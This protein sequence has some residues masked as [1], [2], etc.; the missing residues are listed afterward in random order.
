[1]DPFPAL[2]EAFL[3][4]AEANSGLRKESFLEQARHHIAEGKLRAS[5]R[6]FSVKWTR[7]LKLD[8]G[9]GLIFRA[10]VPRENK[11]ES[12]DR[13]EIPPLAMADHRLIFV[14]G[15]KVDCQ[16][17]RGGSFDYW[18]A[19]GAAAYSVCMSGWKDVRGVAGDVERL[20]PRTATSPSAIAATDAG[21]IEPRKRGPK[22]ETMKRVKTEMRAHAADDLSAMKIVEMESTFNASSDT[23]RRAREEIL[24]E[25]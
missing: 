25:K 11:T 10:D 12:P 17:V 14:D 6:R 13:V 7:R 22:P 23:C 4:A 2:Y 8:P 19:K 3:R 18:G 20:W 21:Q 24:A 9:R 5:G 1:M 15:P 16:V